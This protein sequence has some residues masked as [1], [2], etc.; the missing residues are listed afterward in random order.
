MGTKSGEL[1]EMLISVIEG[2][3][4]GKVEPDAGRAIAALAAQVNVSLQIEV[5]AR[6]QQIKWQDGEKRALGHMPLGEEARAIDVTAER[7]EGIDG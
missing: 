1:R 3:Q 7:A 6:I 4:N 2:V 5:N